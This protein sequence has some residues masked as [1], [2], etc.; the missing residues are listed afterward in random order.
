MTHN[1]TLP[2]TKDG[3]IAVDEQERVSLVEG[4][5][6]IIYELKVLLLTIQ[7]EDIFDEEHGLRVFEVAG[8]S[9]DVLRRE[10]KFALRDDDRVSAVSEVRIEGCN[11]NACKS[12]PE[13][14]RERERF[15]RVLVELEDYSG[16]ESFGVTYNE[17]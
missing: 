4:K 8:S 5:R 10:I 6:A 17:Q 9:N 15:V 3:D 1:R 13:D 12:V 16:I 14:T 11:T 2:L 7:G